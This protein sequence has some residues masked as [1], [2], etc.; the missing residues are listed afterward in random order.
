MN[1]FDP[2]TKQAWTI[3]YSWLLNKSY[4]I[5]VT[6]W[7]IDRSWGTR[8]LVLS[9]TGKSFSFPY[10][11]TMTYIWVRKTIHAHLLQNKYLN[12]QQLTGILSGNFVLMLATSSLRLAEEINIKK[13]LKFTKANVLILLIH[14]TSLECNQPLLKCMIISTIQRF[15]LSVWY[16]CHTVTHH[17]TKFF[18]RE[19]LL[20]LNMA[21]AMSRY[22]HHSTLRFHATIKL[23]P[24]SPTNCAYIIHIYIAV[25]S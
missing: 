14:N 1:K 12:S 6:N 21:S 11:S 22:P 15:W 16:C 17:I 18:W 8:N 3:H 10:L 7:L 13:L 2:V 20:G 25:L 24:S 5:I 4:L 23:L 19:T 9:R